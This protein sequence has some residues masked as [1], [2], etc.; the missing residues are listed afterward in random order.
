MIYFLALVPATMLTMAGYA[1]LFLAHRSEGGLK[2]FGRYLSF[3]AFT[4]AA[5]IVL[6][7]IVAGARGPC[8]HGM[9]MPGCA[10]GAAMRQC[11]DMRSWRHPPPSGAAQGMPAAPPV[12][13][14]APLEA[15]PPK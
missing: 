10:G 12:P 4:L 8:M 9:M 13:P 6:G 3:W 7:A 14:P 5:L 15:A 1:V 11:P 2:S